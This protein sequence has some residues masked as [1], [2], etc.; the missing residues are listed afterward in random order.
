MRLPELPENS[1]FVR[2][3]TTLEYYEDAISGVLKPESVILDL[4]CGKKSIMANYKGKNR[5]SIGMDI[6]L[7]AIK[8]NNAFNNLIVG[9]S[10]YLPFKN[11]SFDIIT[12]QWMMEHIRF[13]EKV[14]KEVYRVLKLGGSIIVATNS[15]YHLMMFL[16]AILP[17]RLRDNLKTKI[18]PSYIEEDTFPTYYRFNSLNHIHKMLLKKG[19]ERRSAVYSGAPFFLF[20]EY[21]FKLSE[22]YERVTD[23]DLLRFLK[24]HL[25]IHYVKRQIKE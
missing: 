22:I 10:E 18:L 17:L 2:T 15:R 3:K 21:L 4:G 5:L 1:Y 13:P 25:V 16:S 12:S 14:I 20:S 8:L 24:M 23:I 7:K 9:S 19:F 6:S 11:E